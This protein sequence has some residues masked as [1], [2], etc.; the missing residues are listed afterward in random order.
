MRGSVSTAGD[1]LGYYLRLT[2]G[3]RYFAMTMVL[4]IALPLTPDDSED[5]S[6][7]RLLGHAFHSL[8]Y[9]KMVPFMRRPLMEMERIARLKGVPITK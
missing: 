5:L 8:S 6:Y 1:W 4:I 2:L 3:H 7:R 9:W